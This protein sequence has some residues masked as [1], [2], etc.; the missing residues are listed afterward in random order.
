MSFGQRKFDREKPEI[1]FPAHDDADVRRILAST[2]SGS[3]SHDATAA[4]QGASPGI[5]PRPR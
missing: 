5:G 3:T 4:F 1:E 2:S